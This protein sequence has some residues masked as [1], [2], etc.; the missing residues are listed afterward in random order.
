MTLSFLIF[1]I[2]MTLSFLIFHIV[3]LLFSHLP[4]RHI[5]LLSHLPHRH[6]TLFYH[7]PHR[8]VTLFSH[9][10]HRHVTL[11]S[12]LP[13]RHVTLFSHLPHR[14]VTLFSSSTSSCHSLF[15][16]STSSCHS[17]FSSSTSSCYSLV[18]S[19]ISSCYS[20]V[21][22]SIFLWLLLDLVHLKSTVNLLLTLIW[23][24]YL[25]I[26]F[27][28]LFL[29][30]KYACYMCSRSWWI[31]HRCIALAGQTFFEWIMKNQVSVTKKDWSNK[32]RVVNKMSVD[33]V[34]TVGVCQDFFHYVIWDGG[35]WYVEVSLR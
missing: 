31:W 29:L 33:F 34:I 12:H 32:M 6:V 17:L 3:M 30:Y 2:V 15:S 18:W 7:L 13:H 19:S 8:H 4:H 23:P 25:C 14:H 20:L 27:M 28:I 16:S 10:S 21:W 11:F 9:L 5:T 22:S 35:R 1:H 26:F 24:M